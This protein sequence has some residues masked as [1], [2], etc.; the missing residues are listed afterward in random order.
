MVDVHSE[1]LADLLSRSE[2]SELD[3]KSG[4]LL[5]NPGHENRKKIAQN[6]VGFA[7]RNGGK[8]VIGVDDNTREPE[9]ASIREE[10]ATGIISEISRDD[11]SPTVSFTHEFYSSQKGDL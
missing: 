3:F 4:E 1:D 2:S 6:L 11:C 5:T 9:G 10:G 7:N 8:L